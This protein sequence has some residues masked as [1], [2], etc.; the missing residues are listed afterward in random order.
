MFDPSIIQSLVETIKIL[1]AYG[2]AKC[3]YI[4]NTIRN[5]DTNKHFITEIGKY[6]L[7]TLLNFG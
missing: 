7:N 1:L 6:T 4:C 3:A 5:V 2:N